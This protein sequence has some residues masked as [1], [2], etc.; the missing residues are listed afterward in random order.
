VL[1]YVGYSMSTKGRER[2]N[3]G[4]T[5]LL[6]ND[7]VDPLTQEKVEYGVRRMPLGLGLSFI[8]GNVS[9][10]LGIGGGVIKVPVMNLVLGIPLRAAIATSNFMIGITAATS[11]IIYYQ[12]GLIDLSVA[13]PTA[14]GVLIGAHIGARVGTHVKRSYLRRI[15]QVVLFL[16]ALIMFYKAYTG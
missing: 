13:I 4:K 1:I 16:F 11:A 6:D 15:F 7:F 3:R 9:G 2:V 10:L 12:R 5:G 14:L 8:A